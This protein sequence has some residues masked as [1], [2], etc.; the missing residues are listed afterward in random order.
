MKAYQDCSDNVSSR[1]LHLQLL[2]EA[3][4][5]YSENNKIVNKEKFACISDYLLRINHWN[6][7]EINLLSNFLFIFDQEILTLL[8]NKLLSKLEEDSRTDYNYEKILINTLINLS[9]VFI[10]KDEPLTSKKF[11]IK[12]LKLSLQNNMLYEACLAK[13]NYLLADTYL[14]KEIDESIYTYSE[15]LA[16]MGYDQLVASIHQEIAVC[17]EK[18]RSQM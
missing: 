5:E 6:Y 12:A 3:I 14:T 16:F 9:D 17:L 7:Y 11:S 1:L 10:K 8:G 13:I 15:F 18:S 2:Y 4:L